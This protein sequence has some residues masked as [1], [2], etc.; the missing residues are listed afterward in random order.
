MFWTFC[1]VWVRTL[2]LQHS[3]PKCQKVPMNVHNMTHIPTNC[4]IMV[5]KQFIQRNSALRRLQFIWPSSHG[6]SIKNNCGKVRRAA[7]N[8]RTSKATEEALNLSSQSLGPRGRVLV[9]LAQRR[10]CPSYNT[11]A[12]E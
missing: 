4:T 2:V 7:G 1:L 11:K 9:Q 12:Q 10:R 5:K 3:M 8:G 6:L